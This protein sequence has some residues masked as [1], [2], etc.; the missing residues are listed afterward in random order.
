MGHAM[1][2][3]HTN[4]GRTLMYPYTERYKDYKVYTPRPDDVNGIHYLY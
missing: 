2:L 1:G 4:D 3:A